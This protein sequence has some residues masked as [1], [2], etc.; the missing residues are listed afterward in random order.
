MSFADSNGDHDAERPQASL[1]DLWAAV[2]ALEERFITLIMD[3]GRG[4][5]PP[6][7][8]SK[9]FAALREGLQRI[10]RRF[11]EVRE[12]RDLGFQSVTKLEELDRFSVWLYRRIRFEDLFYRKLN[13]EA[14]LRARISS[15]AYAL[16]E[17]LTDAED[18]E[19]RL[20]SQ[21]DADI[22]SELAGAQASTRP[23]GCADTLA[24]A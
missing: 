8:L 3:A 11:A 9:E 10:Y 17:E 7:D 21:E 22:K 24:E 4:V 2:R 6:G 5:I 18:E 12:R 16:Y 13:L 14:Q 23:P 1:G 19:K 20:L 15:D